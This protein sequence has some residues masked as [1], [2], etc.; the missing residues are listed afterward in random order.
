MIGELASSGEPVLVVCA[1]ALW[2]RGIVESAV[3]PGRYGGGETAIVA[4]R[5]SIPL[6]VEKAKEIAERS[7]VA[8]VDWGALSLEPGLVELFKHVVLADPAPHPVMESLVSAGD[9]YLHV[10]AAKRELSL[11]AIAAALPDRKA[12]AGAYR[13]IREHGA[14]LE[15]AG[16]RS[17]PV[18][19]RRRGKVARS[20]RARPPRARRDRRRAGR[21]EGL[22]GQR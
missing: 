5:G 4:S 22:C 6:G 8:L 2:R 12:L 15:A 17:R 14:P 13:A 10:L 1:D 11:G 18:W 20:V 21:S 19:R 16:L 9:G 3:H 7:G